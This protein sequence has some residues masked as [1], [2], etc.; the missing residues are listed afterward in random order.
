VLS[1]SRRVPLGVAAVIGVVAL[2]DLF[3]NIPIVPEGLKPYF[4]P[5]ILIVTGAYLIW[6]PRTH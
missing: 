2:A 1:P 6:E 4:V 3:T 5:I